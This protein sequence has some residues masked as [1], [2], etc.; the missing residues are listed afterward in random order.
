MPRGRPRYEKKDEAVREPTPEPKKVQLEA[1]N[2]YK[3]PGEDL[4]YVVTGLDEQEVRVY[5]HSGSSLVGA[6]IQTYEQL[7]RAAKKMERSYVE[8]LIEH[9]KWVLFKHISKL[10]E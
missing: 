5:R 7:E 10:W 1:G 4:Y 9:G 6:E 3:Y 2:V 8:S